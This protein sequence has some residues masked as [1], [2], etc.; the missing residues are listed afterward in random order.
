MPRHPATV[1]NRQRVAGVIVHI[2]EVHDTCVVII[3]PREQRARK[4]GRMHV[5]ERVGVR[6]PPP[7]AKVKATDTGIMVVNNDNLKNTR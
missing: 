7:K 4:V 1:Q 5:C 6:I 3:L 2:L